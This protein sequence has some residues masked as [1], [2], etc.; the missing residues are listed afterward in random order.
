[1]YSLAYNIR[2]RGV[3]LTGLTP[4]H[5]GRLA[6]AVYFYFYQLLTAVN[7]FLFLIQQHR[8]II[9]T[10]NSIITLIF[11]K[12][13]INYNNRTTQY[14]SNIVVRLFIWLFI[15]TF[16]FS[17]DYLYWHSHFLMI[18]YSDIPIFSWLFIVTFPFFLNNYLWWHSH[19]LMIIYNDIPIF[20]WLFIE[21]F[22]FSHDYIQ[23][24]SHFLIIIYRHSHFLIIILSDIPIFSLLLIKTFPFSHDYF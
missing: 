6:I 13:K 11:Q 17:H 2:F 15:E 21:T 22:P 24:H 20:S 3:P 1:L 12:S 8:T 5:N 4:P 14:F 16:T 23:W 19:F 7:N 9:N 10:I 18:I